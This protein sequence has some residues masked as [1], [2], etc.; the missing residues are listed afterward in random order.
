M[1]KR[2]CKKC[3]RVSTIVKL[4]ENCIFCCDISQVVEPHEN[5]FCSYCGSSVF[6]RLLGAETNMMFYGDQPTIPLDS[7]YDK[8]TGQRNYCYKYICPHYKE[9]KWFECYSPHDNYFVDVVIKI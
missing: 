9:K 8:K 1:N 3:G 7:A 5:R 6:E 4:D 2:E